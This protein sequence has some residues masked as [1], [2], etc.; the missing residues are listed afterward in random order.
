[1]KKIESYI[2]TS[3]V[4]ACINSFIYGVENDLFFTDLNFGILGFNSNT[5][6]SLKDYY[7][8]FYNQV[9]GINAY[10]KKVKL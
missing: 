3:C 7:I 2:N 1:M 4:C 8:R 10:E 6:D 5:L 9:Y